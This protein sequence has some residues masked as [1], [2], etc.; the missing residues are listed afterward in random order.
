MR[1]AILSD[2]HGNADA[3]RAVLDDLSRQ[4]PCDMTLILGDSVTMGPDAVLVAE[5]L[6]SIPKSFC[7]Q[8]NCDRWVAFGG[9]PLLP[10]DRRTEETLRMSLLVA[11]NCGWSAGQLAAAGHLAWLREL[12]SEF[13]LRLPSGK[14]LL[15]VH[16]SPASDEEGMDERTPANRLAELARAANADLIIAGHVHHSFSV[17][18]EGVSIHTVASVSNPVGPEKSAAYALLDATGPDYVLTHRSVGY[19]YRGPVARAR[20]TGHPAAEIMADHFGL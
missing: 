5:T 2:I 1:A 4:T 13:R 10:P 17:T 16:G 19:D 20:Q 18:M 12:P 9:S 11:R 6:R 14:R 7:I 15:A 8:G 3:L